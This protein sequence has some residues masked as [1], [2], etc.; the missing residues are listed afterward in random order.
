M[1]FRLLEGFETKRANATKLD[2]AYTR[3]GSTAFAGGRKSLGFSLSSNSCTLTSDELV[4]PDENIW[5]V[6]FAIR[7]IAVTAFGASTTAGIQLQNVDGE[8]CSLVL[9]DAGSGSYRVRLKRGSTTIATTTGAFPWGGERSWMYFQLKVTVR[10]GT[11]GVY[12]LRSY[13]Y[14]NNATVEFSGSSVNL[15]EQ[16]TDGADR[17]KISWGV[18]GGSI[19]RIDDIFALDSTGALNNDFLT[20]PPTV[21]GALPNGDGNQSDFTPDSGDNYTNVDDAATTSSDTDKVISSVVSEVDLYTYAPYSLIN[22]SGTDVIG[23]Q[24]MSSAAMVASGSRTVRVRVRESASE[25]FGDNVAL[26]DLILDTYRQMFDQ[27]PTGTPAPWTKATVEA[28]EFGI[29]IQA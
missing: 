13:D 8:Q 9:L 23:V 29:E 7:K 12:E 10:T 11:N 25:A 27:N 26:S 17:I 5:V 21:Q 2:I 3:T 20:P 6:G 28:A 24:V 18:D 14:L 22:A 4:S 16:A 1:V 19:V 15:A